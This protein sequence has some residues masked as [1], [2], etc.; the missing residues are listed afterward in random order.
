[1]PLVIYPMVSAT[2]GSL[3]DYDQIIQGYHP[4]IVWLTDTNV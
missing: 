4:A 2:A 3:E 1:M